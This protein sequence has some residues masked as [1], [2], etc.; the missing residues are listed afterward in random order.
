MPS[1]GVVDPS[2]PTRRRD[3]PPLFFFG[4]LLV[5]SGLA[6]YF[7][8]ILFSVV[9]LILHLGEP[10]RTWNAAIVW[11]SGIPSTVGLGL[12]GLDLA[13]LLPAKRRHSLSKALEPVGDGK[14]V[15]ALTAYNDEESIGQ[16]VVDFRVQQGH[17]ALQTFP[18]GELIRCAYVCE[19]AAPQMFHL[20][21]LPDEKIAVV[22]ECRELSRVFP[23]LLHDSR[24]V[25]NVG[26]VDVG[27]QL[28]KVISAKSHIA[29]AENN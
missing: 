18:A 22:H 15:V 27:K 6:V 9:R 17:Q 11:Y 20:K 14:V 28:F 10:F 3:L 19:C 1:S 29:L 7:V 25:H 4:T 12:V 21:Q 23:Q 13:L 16:A 8:G 24:A 5:I 2:Q 26:M